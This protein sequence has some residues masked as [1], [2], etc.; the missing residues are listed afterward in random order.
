[1]KVHLETNESPLVVHL[2]PSALGR[3][4]Q[5]AARTLVDR[6]DDSGVIR[7]RL[8]TLFAGPGEVEVDLSLGHNA[9]GISAEGF[10]LRVARALRKE[11][12]RLKPAVVVAHGGDPMK[13]AVP[14]TVGT[15]RSLVY[16]VIGTYS[17]APSPWHEWLWKR[18]MSRADLVVAVGD[19]VRDECTDRFGVAADRAIVIPNGR[20]PSVFHPRPVVADASTTLIFVGALTAQ[21]QPNRF[22]DV[23]G[24]L[25]AEGHS[26]RALMVG[27]GPLSRSL[28]ATAADNR[29]ELLGARADVP[30]LLRQADVLVFTSRPTGE[31]MPGVFIEAGL[32][33]LAVVS[34]PVPGAADVLVPGRTGLIVDDD[35][36]ALARAVGQLLS[37]P[38]RRSAMGTAARRR[39][40]TEFSLDLMAQRWR[41]ALQ[42]LT[43]AHPGKSAQMEC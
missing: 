17:G 41:A 11:L 19:E 25:R 39:C 23:V 9:A 22:V 18:I 42:P 4:A 15:Q 24:R 37:D 7:H 26:F 1:M 2:I 6:L 30:K 40:E 16:C 21:K 20:D 33:G 14:A 34:T 35:I 27:D 31:G 12:E 28:A 8:L 29:I 43:F 38:Q 5:R 13:Y 36:G 10:D 32:S 3:G